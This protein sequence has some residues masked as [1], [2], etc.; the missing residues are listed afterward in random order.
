MGVVLHSCG[1]EESPESV[2]SSSSEVDK[3]MEEASDAL[4]NSDFPLSVEKYTECLRYF[5]EKKDTAN[6]SECYFQLSSNFQ[7]LG[8]FQMALNMAEKC[9]HLDSCMNEL[10]NMSSSYNN[11]AAISLAAKDLESARK[12]ILKA[13]ELEEETE[14]QAKMSVRYGIASEIYT[15]SDSAELGYEYAQKAYEL[16]LEKGDSVKIGKRLSQMG[17]ALSAMG[18]LDEAEESYHDAE[19][20]LSKA[21]DKT[22]MCI[23][24]KQL[25][26]LYSKEG[27]WESAIEYHEK[28]LELARKYNLNYL[29]ENNLSA[30]SKL[31]NLRDKGRAL[32]YAL[33]DMTWKD[34]IY[35]QEMQQTAQQFS[36]QYDLWEKEKRI[37]RQANRI[38]TQKIM[39]WTIFI[40]FILIVLLL[41]LYVYL[42]YI[43]KEKQELHIKYSHALITDFNAS[44]PSPETKSVHNDIDIATE[45]DR[46]FLLKVN[47]VISRHIDEATLSSVKIAEEVC[48]GQRQVNRK[49]KAITGIDTGT[50]IK[51]KRIGKA[52][53]LLDSS[54]LNIG[55]IQSACGFESP[56]YFS[57]VFKDVVG[58]SPS[59]YRK[60]GRFN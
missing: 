24:Y 33:E 54:T 23:N 12:F 17:D 27:K 13:I 37:T 51:M 42:H 15:K 40:A 5:K 45:T 26:T 21:K 31:Y 43:R 34:S 9:L 59:E 44:E 50:Y 35:N 7:R 3:L 32:E 52:R 29:I 22:S 1:S 18:R 38:Q 58:M 19:P 60:S 30:L 25:G 16:D 47:D 49:V 53:Q 56:S 48:L 55:E 4:D 14:E 20:Y 46:E 10:E 36:A 39:I 8:N 11:M 41:G 2:L 28:S 6:M 57:R